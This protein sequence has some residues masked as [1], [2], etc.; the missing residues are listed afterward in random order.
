MSVRL[1]SGRSAVRSRPWPPGLTC[2]DTVFA[3]YGW[4]GVSG[5]PPV[6]LV[7]DRAVEP[8]EVRGYMVKFIGV[9]IA[10]DIRGDG[11]CRVAHGFPDVAKVSAGGSGQAGV[12]VP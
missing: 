11:R 2:V 12:G 5:F 8:V 6:R 4:F 3:L 10:V 9:E 1:K 7:R